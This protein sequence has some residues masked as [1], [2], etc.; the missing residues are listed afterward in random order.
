MDSNDAV[1]I[2][3]HVGT[4]K[5]MMYLTNASGSWPSPASIYGYGGWGSVM[6]IDANDDVFIPNNAPGL[7]LLQMT[8]VKG[9][10][11]GLTVR[12]IYDVSPMLPDGLNMNWRTGTISGTPT[13]THTNTTH[14]VTVTALGTTTTATFTLL[15]TGVP[16]DIS[17]ANITGTKGSPIVSVSPSF[18]NGSTSGSVTSWAINATPPGGLSFDTSTGVIS[19]TPTVV[20]VGAVFTVWGNNSAGS[21]STTVNITVNDVAVSSFTYTAE[22]STLTLYHTMATISATT[23]GGTPTSWGIHPALPSGLT[24]NTVTGAIS[25]TPE[26]LQ[27]TTVTYTVWANNSGGSFSDQINITVN[28]H[29][30]VPLNHFGGNIT[31]NFNQTM[32]PL[33]GFELK[34]DVLSAGEDHT[35]AIRDDGRVLC[36]G[37]GDYGKLGIG[38]TND[39]SSPQFTNSLGT[40]R[41]AI[42]ISAGGEHTCAVLDNGS[43]M[44]WGRD[45]YGQ[46]GD[47]TSGGQRVSPT[48]TVGLPRPA[49]AVEVGM[50]FS[51]AL[52]NNG[53]VMCWGR[54][55]GGRLGNGGTSNSAQPVYTDPMP[56]GRKA[57]AI[58]ISH[59]HTCAVLDDGNVAC[60]GS[61]GGGR[62]GTGSNNGESSPTLANYFS[63]TNQAVD[64]ALGRYTGCALMANG[65]VTCW[66][67]GYLGDGNGETTKTSPGLA[68]VNLPSGRTAVSVE[69]GRKHACMQLD[70]GDVKCWGDDQYGQ[71]ANGNGENDRNNPTTVNF[72]SGIEAASIHAGHWHNCITAQTNEVYCWG[73]GK[74]GKLGDGGTTQHNFAGAASKTNHFS[75]S[76]PVLNH[77]SITSWTVH[78]ALPTGLSLGSTNGTIWGTP[79]ASISQTNFTVYANNSGG[80]S[81]F[82]LNLGV[83]LEAPGPFQYIPENNTLTNNTEVYL[84]PQFLNQTTGNGSTWNVA[85]IN[86][87]AGNSNPGYYMEILVGDTIYFSANDGIKG[88][89][90]WAY[91]TS[92]H[93]TW[94]VADIFSGSGK[95]WPGAYMHLLVGDTIYFSAY[96]G[97]TGHELWAHDTSNHSTWR[98][99]DINFCHCR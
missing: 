83:D 21:T 3:Y 31:L 29:P 68:W 12:P 66:G 97:N 37:E 69:M 45:N 72:A 20:V 8:T 4:N 74:A 30:P 40:G 34:P 35:C 89:E 18:S 62:L 23:T 33:G 71:M 98:V 82:V 36:W 78:P 91:N 54:G 7:G 51:C 22:N 70:N 65:S 13:E 92:N 81:S 75:G 84:V 53:S 46:I 5:D 93:S 79:T 44:C 16:G 61:G 52:L 96:D 90:L 56:G 24:F 50:D 41:K 73:D 43:V 17:Y 1:H 19:G 64:V 11:Q 26:V 99:T 57:V 10:G 2:T 6:H 42:D 15:V 9:S 28:D 80:S 67:E 25:G 49:V 77:G 76:K 94:R 38:N 48:H 86:S 87:G 58:D 59:Y 39:K 47:G 60:W 55:S 27:T 63:S 85:D 95:S 32:T 14:T 88:D